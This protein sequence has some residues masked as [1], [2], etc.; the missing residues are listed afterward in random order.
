MG[1]SKGRRR[2][3]ASASVVI[4]ANSPHRLEQHEAAGGW[5]SRIKVLASSTLGIAAS[6]EGG[7]CVYAC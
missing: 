1:T 4:A 5:P 2:S 6:R 7:D 3:G